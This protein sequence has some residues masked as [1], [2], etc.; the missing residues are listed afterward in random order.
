M[1]VSSVLGGRPSGRTSPD[2]SADSCRSVRSG[3][4]SGQ[5]LVFVIAC[6]KDTF[7]R[8]QSALP[9]AMQVLLTLVLWVGLLG[10]AIGNPSGCPLWYRQSLKP[11][12]RYQRSVKDYSIEPVLIEIW[13]VG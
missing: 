9:R 12:V 6:N 7:Y 1:R 4:F 10:F 8:V 3:A 5:D 13:L 2:Y 11:L